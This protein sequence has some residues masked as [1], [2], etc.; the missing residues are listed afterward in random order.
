[1]RKTIKQFK[2][3]ARHLFRLCIVN[4]ELDDAFVRQ[5]LEH[6]LSSKR[7]GYLAL[8]TQFERLVRVER[9]RQSASK[10][11]A[12]LQ[13]ELATSLASLSGDRRVKQTWK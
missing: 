3:E 10:L 1:M 12:D 13:T 8:A 2:R 11:P 6:V 4:G 9:Q 7:H 5:V